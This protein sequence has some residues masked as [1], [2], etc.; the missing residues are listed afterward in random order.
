VVAELHE[1]ARRIQTH[2]RVVVDVRQPRCQVAA[3]AHRIHG[4]PGVVLL[5]H[6]QRV[7]E[8][9]QIE[10]RVHDDRVKGLDSRLVVAA[11]DQF[12][13]ERT[14]LA[15]SVLVVGALGEQCLGL[16]GSIKPGHDL[17]ILSQFS[18]SRINSR[19]TC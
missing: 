1:H 10:I 13:D 17:R 4:K 11:A 9:G 12:L 19:A 15:T 3:R 18:I 14:Q 2:G 7:V 5:C 8:G 16:V 6:P